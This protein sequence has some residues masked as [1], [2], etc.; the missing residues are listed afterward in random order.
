MNTGY[1]HVFI[2][3]QIPKG[4]TW[5]KMAKDT[6]Y[7]VIAVDWELTDNIMDFKWIF[8]LGLLLHSVFPMRRCPV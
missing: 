1:Q 2:D 3:P 6:P 4:L 8:Q 5:A 7:G